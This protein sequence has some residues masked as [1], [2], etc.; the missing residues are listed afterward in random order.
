MSVDATL[1]T[2]ASLS[3]VRADLIQMNGIYPNKTLQWEGPPVNLADNAPCIP[4]GFTWLP[5][6]FMN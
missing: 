5:I 6:S 2:G 4:D 3:A 1:D